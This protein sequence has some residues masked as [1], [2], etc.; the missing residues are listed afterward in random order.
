MGRL[1][2]TRRSSGYARLFR[3]EEL[4]R[5]ALKLQGDRLPT[6]AGLGAKI[7]RHLDHIAKELTGHD[8][9]KVFEHLA[10]KSELVSMLPTKSGPISVCQ[11]TCQHL[12]PSAGGLRSQGHLWRV[13]IRASSSLMLVACTRAEEETDAF[14][15]LGPVQVFNVRSGLGHPRTVELPSPQEAVKGITFS[16][17]APAV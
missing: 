8:R 3:A 13:P 17:Q 11:P 16:A 5:R 4:F 10:S 9:R 12:I 14:I 2:G 15:A 6:E 7:G 1:G